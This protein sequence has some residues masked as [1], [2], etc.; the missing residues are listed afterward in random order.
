MKHSQQQ[1]PG[2]FISTLGDICVTN[3]TSEIK[4]SSLNLRQSAVIYPE[5]ERKGTP[6]W[7]SWTGIKSRSETEN[8]SQKHWRVGLMQCEQGWNPASL[9][10]RCLLKVAFLSQLPP[11]L[12]LSRVVCPP[13]FCLCF[14]HGRTPE[15]SF[16]R[17]LRAFFWAEPR[18]MDF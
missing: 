16:G 4:E 5:E 9:R 7:S 13:R 8:L 3:Y 6:P 10:G 11:S 15:R 17:N 12:M 18:G 14:A 1:Q 2:V